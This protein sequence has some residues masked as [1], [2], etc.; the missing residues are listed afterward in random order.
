ML[1]IAA[2]RGY[3]AIT[4][5]EL[6]RLAGVSTKT[7]Y[8]HYSGKEE[9]FLRTHELVVRRLLRSMAEAQAVEGDW[10]RRLAGTFRAFNRDLARDPRVAQMILI[11][12][13]A[14]GETAFD[15]VCWAERSFEVCIAE[16]LDGAPD[17]VERRTLLVRA[18]RASMMSVAG[19]RV[20]AGR[21]DAL[22]GLAE[23]L[24]DWAVSF[25]LSP[26]I[27]EVA[28]LERSFSV[29][30]PPSGQLGKV[31]DGSREPRDR[32]RDLA[33][34]T[35]AKLISTTGFESLTAARICLAA[36][37]SRER[38]ERF[39]GLDAC[40]LKAL[41]L[42]WSATLQNAAKAK[43]MGNSE[44]DCIHRVISLLCDECTN[45]PMQAK[46][47]F[48]GASSLGSEGMRSTQRFIAELAGLLSDEA[49]LR[50]KR[51]RLPA[52]ASAG[53]IYGVIR[54]YVLGD[55]V[56]RLPRL[57]KFLVGLTIVPSEVGHRHLMA[58]IHETTRLGR[59]DASRY[60]AGEERDRT[61]VASST[62]RLIP[63]APG[64]PAEPAADITKPAEQSS[65]ASRRG[66]NSS[67]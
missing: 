36:G 45:D 53:A 58:L 55:R 17:G 64:A 1:E 23:G 3:K 34:S 56:Q 22:P 54:H 8:E 37:I 63:G 57:T 4:L 13:Y 39:G 25:F 19:S 50:D 30:G 42:R 59:P 41:D 14:A 67:C 66:L 29:G 32:D 26:G 35:V 60:L 12:A 7:F 40:L 6:A 2:E 33:L 11:E 51:A 5:R 27:T 28:E 21:V 38:F 62:G 24:A 20:L 44:L 43:A 9:C 48:A 10:R 46:L 18:F 49:E 15:Q 16:G 47:R 52:E 65:P 61:A 31:E